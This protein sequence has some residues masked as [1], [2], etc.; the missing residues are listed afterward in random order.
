ME[1]IAL[2]EY[3]DKYVSLYQGEIRN[4]VDPLAERLIAQGVV[5]EHKDKQPNWKL[6]TQLSYSEP[7]PEI[8]NFLPE[9]TPIKII[10]TSEND[11]F[12]EFIINNCEIITEQDYK[13]QSIGDWNE[14]S[15]QPIFSQ[16]PFFISIDY[17]MTTNEYQI[18]SQLSPD[19]SVDEESFK[20]S[21]YYDDK[22]EDSSTN[23]FQLEIFEADIQYSNSD[24]WF[25]SHSF[26]ELYEAYQK[27]QLILLKDVDNTSSG[28]VLLGTSFGKYIPQE[29]NTLEHFEFL[30]D[31]FD[32][33]TLTCST[34]TLCFYNDNSF[35]EEDVFVRFILEA[36]HNIF[37]TQS[38]NNSTLSKK[39]NQIKASFSVPSFIYLNITS[40]NNIKRYTLHTIS[41]RIVD[42]RYQYYCTFS[43]GQ[44]EREYIC[45]SVTESPHLSV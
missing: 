33:Y 40:G 7:Q 45:S 39:Y 11:S 31:V 8:S 14:E 42:D 10:L 20:I 30:I 24:G 32:S 35:R 34:Y 36:P 22:E 1:I 28:I 18:F 4:I 23:D 19:L 37:L 26:S 16:Y 43:N 5:A 41:S 15:S 2:Q 13:F 17:D 25:I 29:N 44:E 38:G 12:S 21:I 9:N 27:N 6:F 3:T